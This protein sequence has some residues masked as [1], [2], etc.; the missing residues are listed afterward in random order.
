MEEASI[1]SA[2]ALPKRAISGVANAPKRSRARTLT[3]IDKR[4]LLWKRLVELRRLFS[5]ALTQAGI[6]LSPVR[7]LKVEQ[8]AQAV[9]VAEL[10]RGKFMRDGAGDLDELV[11]AERRA[12]AAVK[13]LGLP[14]EGKPAGP[15]SPL[16]EH[17]SRP[18]APEV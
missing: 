1:S 14:P 5:A 16:V 2:S 12:D 3:T 7:A 6:E 8:A 4:T 13:R 18:P 10:C 15:M 9:A 17:F 11:R